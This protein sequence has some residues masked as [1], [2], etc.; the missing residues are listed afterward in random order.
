MFLCLADVSQ[1][2]SWHFL[3]GVR[4]RVRVSECVLKPPSD[5]Y[6]GLE[7]YSLLYVR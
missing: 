7:D 1:S 6:S 2:V 5:G 3:R 4:V